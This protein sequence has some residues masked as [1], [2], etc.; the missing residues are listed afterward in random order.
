MTQFDGVT[1]QQLQK[2]SDIQNLLRMSDQQL[3]SMGYTD[4]GERHRVIVCQRVGKILEASNA[5]PKEKQ[6]GELAGYLHD[7]GCCINR[8][9]HAH[10]GGIM[11]LRLLAE[12]GMNAHDCAVVANA[13]ANHDEKTGYSCN[14][15]ASALIL[16]DKSDVHRNR[17]RSNK[18]SE[19][20][21]LINKE[22][23]H[24]RVNYS[25]IDSKLDIDTDSKR[26]IFRFVLDSNVSSAM[27][28]FEIFLGRMKMCKQAAEVLGMTFNLEINGQILA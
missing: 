4:H 2:D 15:V 28:Y 11:A 6:L 12:R 23:I 1:V 27:E 9:N 17:V 8:H 21:T 25:V 16:A 19:D 20:R 5:S 22:D 10:T 13:I 14:K 18:L 24:D 26:I 3:E 7:I